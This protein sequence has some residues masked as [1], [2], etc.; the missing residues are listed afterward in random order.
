M[1]QKHFER[2]ILNETEPGG[3][4]DLEQNFSFFAPKA[5]K[6]TSKGENGKSKQN[7][8]NWLKNLGFSTLN[9]FNIRR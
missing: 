6:R 5:Y 9:P 2:R 7:T 3:R 8:T 1:K 4:T